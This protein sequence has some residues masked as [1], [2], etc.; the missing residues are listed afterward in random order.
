MWISKKKL[1]AERAE[2]ARR[3]D[4]LLTINDYLAD[5]CKAF[6]FKLGQ[7]VYDLQLRSSKG[8]YTKTKPS[9]EHSVVNEIVVDKKNYF[10]LVDRYLANDVFTSLTDAEAYLKKVC[11]D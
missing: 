11:V 6:P 8:R 10:G 3:Y 9:I 2:V 1:M 4:E 7:V 5:Y